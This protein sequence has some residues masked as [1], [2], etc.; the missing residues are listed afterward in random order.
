MIAMYTLPET[1]VAPESLGLEDV[2][3]FWA[4]VSIGGISLNGCCLG[5]A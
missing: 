2:I 4:H 1:N 5:G 3:S